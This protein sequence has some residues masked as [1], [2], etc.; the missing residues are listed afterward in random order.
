MAAEAPPPG[1]SVGPCAALCLLP[2]PADAACILAA[3]CCTADLLD[4]CISIAAGLQIISLF[5]GFFAAGIRI[6]GFFAGYFAAGL[7][8]VTSFIPKSLWIA[9]F[10]SEPTHSSTTLESPGAEPIMTS[11]GCGSHLCVL[12]EL[13]W[14]PCSVVIYESLKKD[15]QMC[16]EL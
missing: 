16:Q 9:H 13:M 12:P 5:A 3:G 4:A 11:Q 15:Q 2:P 6:I 7:L 1:I 8:T 10:S 14:Q